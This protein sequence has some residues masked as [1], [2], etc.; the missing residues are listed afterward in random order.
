MG[1]AAYNRSP[2]AIAKIIERGLGDYNKRQFRVQLENAERKISQLE[3]FCVNSRK[4]LDGQ[5]YNT[6]ANELIEYILERQD[7]KK[8]TKG[9]RIR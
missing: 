3:E 4:L 6:Y 2:Q 5:Y 1:V 8:N 7:S 9:F